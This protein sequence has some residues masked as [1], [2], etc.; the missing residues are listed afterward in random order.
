MILLSMS[1]PPIA[2]F[3][4]ILTTM[5]WRIEQINLPFFDET[6]LALINDSRQYGTETLANS[7]RITRQ[8]KWISTS[9][10]Q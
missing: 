4:A 5:F 8:E 1:L 10:I 6:V 3:V 2:D 7:W 9:I